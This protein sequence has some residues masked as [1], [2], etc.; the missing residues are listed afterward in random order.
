MFP[1]ISNL[2]ISWPDP[3]VM[4]P[5][6]AQKWLQASTQYLIPTSSTND[7]STIGT[8]SN[9]Y[10]WMGCASDKNG[11]VSF[12]PLGGTTS[13]FV[14]TRNAV[15]TTGASLTNYEFASY[16]PYDNKF[17][18]CGSP[19]VKRIS[20]ASTGSVAETITTTTTRGLTFAGNMVWMA[21]SATNQPVRWYN[22]DNGTSGSAGSNIAIDAREPIVAPN[23][24]I[25]LGSAS[26]SIPWYDPNTNTNG[27]IAGIASDSSYNLCLGRDGFIYSVPRFT[28]TSV[29]RID[30]YK[31]TITTVFTGAPYSGTVKRGQWLMPN[32]MIATTQ[33]SNTIILFDPV[34]N[35]SYTYTIT[36]T[37]SGNAMH[38][39]FSTEYGT[40]ISPNGG[41]PFFNKVNNRNILNQA[42]SGNTYRA[43]GQN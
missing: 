43:G 33:G 16:N 28:N 9:S 12:A 5:D 18:Y 40:I 10:T 42:W 30:P 26:T 37:Y 39:G 1:A 35:K 14:D 41:F 17:Y 32:G 31:K 22:I 4:T 38:A 21:P 6:S 27:T 24:I 34:A 19:G 7:T 11:V 13:L 25:F 29:Y 20:A 8:T 36:F 23:G 2:D 3:A 15:I